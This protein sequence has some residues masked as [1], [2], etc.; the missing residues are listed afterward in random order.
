MAKVVAALLAVSQAGCLWREEMVVGRTGAP[1]C[2]WVPLLRD[3][4]VT[5][6][7]RASSVTCSWVGGRPPGCSMLRAARPLDQARVDGAALSSSSRARPAA[8]TPLWSMARKRGKHWWKDIDLVRHEVEQFC[9]TNAL[10]KRTLPSTNQMRTMPGGNHLVHA[11]QMYGGVSNLSTALGIPSFGAS[12]RAARGGV[13]ASSP[14]TCFNA[15]DDSR[16]CF[17][18]S[19]DAAAARGHGRA[20]HGY[21]AD[22]E[23]FRSEL[24][25]FAQQHTNNQVPDAHGVCVC[26]CVRACVRV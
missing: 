5:W 9:D 24:I 20:A 2:G 8:R 15:T 22:G 12:R 1:P 3:P 4:R 14:T 19:A 17:L 25:A 26:V 18:S 11:V 21:F 16:S 10:D 6:C 13:V 7:D 23:R